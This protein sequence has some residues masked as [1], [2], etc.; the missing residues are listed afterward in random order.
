MTYVPSIDEALT[1]F[2]RVL[3]PGG[4]AHMIDNDWDL[5]AVDPCEPEMFKSMME[6]TK[7]LWCNPQAG[8]HLYGAARRAGFKDV[9]VSMFPIIDT[10]GLAFEIPLKACAEFAIEGGFPSEKADQFVV[11]CQEA[12]VKQELVI[13]MPWFI[14]SGTAP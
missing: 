1:E 9:Q 7:Q 5:F 12:L 6:H 14:I 8:R 11:D 10:E 13:I 4:I 2:R 3:K